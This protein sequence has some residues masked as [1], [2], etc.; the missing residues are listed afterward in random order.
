HFPHNVFRITYQC[1]VPAVS[2]E[3]VTKS[4]IIDATGAQFNIHTTCL[5]EAEYMSRYVDKVTS[6]NPAGIAK[7]MYDELCACPGLA[8]LHHLQRRSSAHSIQI[9]IFRWKSTCSLTLSSLLRLPEK[10][11]CAATKK[12]LDL[13]EKEV[14]VFTLIW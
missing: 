4:W 3:P 1:P 9:G 10:E 6:V 13:V 11:Y 8:G 14:K 12:L 5:E 7:A 2:N